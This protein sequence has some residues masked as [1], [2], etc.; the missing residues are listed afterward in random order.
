MWRRL[1][2]VCHEDVLKTSAPVLETTWRESWRRPP[3]F[4]CFQ[5]CEDVCKKSSMK[6]SWRCLHRSWRRLE[7][8]PEDV[9]LVNGFNWSQRCEDVFKKSYMK[10]SWRRLH[11]S[12]KR[13]EGSPEDVPIV[14]GFNCSQRCED[15]FNE[16]FLKTSSDLTFAHWGTTSHDIEAN[17]TMCV[18]VML[19][20][21]MTSSEI[22]R[23]RTTVIRSSYD[24][25]EVARPIH[26][27]HI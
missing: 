21:R 6:T 7:G 15:V 3:S 11:R 22:L 24:I 10:T 13:L 8:S 16:D 12:W 25:I 9:P 18:M 20:R 26:H 14:N 23:H 4:N 19:Q 17:H 1:Q 5:R 2:E 27:S